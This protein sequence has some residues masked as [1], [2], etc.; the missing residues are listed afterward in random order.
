MKCNI[1]MDIGVGVGTRLREK[2]QADHVHHV[3]ES[4]HGRWMH[5]HMLVKDKDI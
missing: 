5:E 2:M 1:G 3:V 4:Y